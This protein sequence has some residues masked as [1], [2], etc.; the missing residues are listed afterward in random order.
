MCN[1][2]K[3]A[4][5]L[6]K[7]ADLDLNMQTKEDE[8][9]ALYFALLKGDDLAIAEKFVELGVDVN[10]IYHK[11]GDSLL[12]KLAKQG[13]AKPSKFV[14]ERTENINY[15]NEDGETALHIACQHGPASLVKTLLD[16]GANPD[17]FNNDG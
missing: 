9:T 1:N 10:P 8:H 3:F 17:L 16:C 11:S 2:T 15:E 4:E 6:L 13:L 5:Q 12:H 14:A 7:C